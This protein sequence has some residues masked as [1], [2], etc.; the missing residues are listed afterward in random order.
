MV[1]VLKKYIFISYLTLLRIISLIIIIKEFSSHF[2]LSILFIILSFIS[3]IFYLKK[4]KVYQVF[5]LENIRSLILYTYFFNTLYSSIPLWD[6]IMHALTG[7]ITVIFILLIY[8]KKKVI[9]P[10]IV[11][12]TLGFCF[13]ITVGAVF[14]IY[15]YSMDNIFKIDM[16]K[17]MFVNNI[18][19]SKYD[20]NERKIKKCKNI[21]KT[22][23][24]YDKNELFTIDGYLDLGINDT[25]K[26]LI[27]NLFGSIMGSMYFYCYK[28]KLML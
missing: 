24:Y 8:R 19:T 18:Y 3:T 17:D 12:I 27:V 5:F 28:E 20:K 2:I 21:E 13:S 7:F 15:E 6:T 26:D 9:L 10:T 22:V 23:I 16:Q 1:V 25:M 11:I 4:K 14:E